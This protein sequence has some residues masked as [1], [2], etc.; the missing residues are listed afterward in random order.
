MNIA[1]LP[2]RALIM[3]ACLAGSAAASPA[4]P[5]PPLVVPFDF[6]RGAIEIEVKVHGQPLRVILD[7]GVDPSVIDLGR[8]QA[9]G[10]RIDRG[11]GGEATG[12]GDGKGAQVF[13]GVIDQLTIGGRA[14]A[15]FDTVVSDM[16]GLSAGYGRSLDG[17][18]GYSFLADKTVLIDYPNHT[19]AFLNRGNE[20]QRLTATCRKRWSAP[21]KTV[22]SFPI[23]PGFRF[24]ASRAPVSLDTGS[25]GAV[26]LFKSALALPGVRANLSENGS[27]T[28]TGARGEAK[29]KSYIFKAPVGFGPFVATETAMSVY[30]EAGSTD[31]RVANVGNKLMADL[32]LKVLFDYRGKRLVFHGACG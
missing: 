6:S 23:I 24:G 14:F 20:A 12:F 27:V 11:D 13:P 9:L 19:V 4:P 10:L 18:I 29:S 16:G 2:R 17:V 25:N 7:T 30:S 31:T 26:S 3:A 15:P 8:A 21:L 5:A 1:A 22:D 32:K 28:R